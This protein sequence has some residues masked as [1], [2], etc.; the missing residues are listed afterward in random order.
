MKHIV[1]KHIVAA[2]ALAV[3]ATL[4]PVAAQAEGPVVYGRLH[5]SLNNVDNGEYSELQLSSNAS[6]LGFKGDH[7]LAEGLKGIYQIESEVVADEGSGTLASRNTFVGLKGSFGTVR[8]GYFDTPIKSIASSVELFGDQVGDA[9]NIYRRGTSPDFNQ[10]EQNMIGYTSPDLNG[11]AVDLAY[12]TNTGTGVCGDGNECTAMIAAVSYKAKNLYVG[13]GYE[14]Y[15]ADPTGLRLGAYYDFGALRVTGLY[16]QATDVAPADSDTM[17]LGVRYTLGQIALKA[18][19]YMLSS[20]ADDSDSALFALGADYKLA[21]N[22]TLYATYASVSNDDNV[23]LVPYRDG[24][25][26]N[27]GDLAGQPGETASGLGLGI[28]YNF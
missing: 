27:S 25:N 18:Q 12:T 7:D 8:T 17:G 21:K 20:D 22:A 2:S 3:A 14:S 9:A 16:Q 11:F 4:A 28:I 6:R 23:A 13:L 5:L 10:R 26:L 15:E 24:P 19:Y 1:S